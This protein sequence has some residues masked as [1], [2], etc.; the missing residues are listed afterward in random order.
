MRKYLMII[1]L[2]KQMYS[3]R[4]PKSHAWT[5]FLIKVRGLQELKWNNKVK[6]DK[7]DNIY[8]TILHTEFLWLL[9]D[10]KVVLVNS[11]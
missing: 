11:C 10:T 1:C 5:S 4:L 8:S 7:T 6:Q 9:Q 2:H 3:I